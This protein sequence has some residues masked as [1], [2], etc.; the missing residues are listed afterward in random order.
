MSKRDPLELKIILLGECGVGKTSIINRYIKNEFD[1]GYESTP[2][3]SYSFK[4][5]EKKKKKY[6]LNLW[7][8]IGQEKFR[9]LSKMFLNDAKIVI[10]VYSIIS[11]ET[12]N[13]LRY[14]LELYKDNKEEKSILGVAANKVDLFEK[15]EVPNEKGKEFAKENGAIFG[16]ISAKE[17]KEGIDIFLDQL[18]DAYLNGNN[19]GNNKEK[20]NIKLEKDQH[21][22]TNKE[23][24]GCCGGKKQNQSQ[25]Q[26]LRKRLKTVSQDTH[27]FVNSI[28]L[29]DS[30][31]GK[32]SIIK[33]IRGIQF[34]R[35]EM[36]TETINECL[37]DYNNDKTKMKMKLKIYDINNEKK[38]TKDFI[39]TLISCNIFFLVYDIKKQES[40]DN[41]ENWIDTIKKCKEE[42]KKDNN[43][44]IYII[45]NKN[46]F[47][48]E[49]DED[50]KGGENEEGI[51]ISNDKNDEKYIDEGKDLSN[52]YNTLFDITSAFENIG[53]ENIVGKALQ[54]YI[55]LP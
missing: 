24:K 20:N 48:F 3:M 36:H 43:C 17:N 5:V 10:L 32:T 46:D 6:K 54:K 31:V 52:K 22:N 47:S 14:W 51:I 45:G 2:A 44:V 12:F 40:L 28:F 27:G 35:N 53:I 55:N 13:N 16:L 11:E 38:S 37:V 25:N 26:A 15:E 21:N 41:L 8:T 4:I 30:G 49:V 1:S 42:E 9:S 7:D 18:L 29:G 33:R 50:I 39:N 19:L 23:K 34:E